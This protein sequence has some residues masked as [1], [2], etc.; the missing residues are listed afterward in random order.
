MSSPII[1]GVALRE[2]DA[3][4]VALA[5][6]LAGVSDRPL[7]LAHVMPRDVPGRLHVPEY[8]QAQRETVQHRLRSVAAALPG[9]RVAETYIVEGSPARGLQELAE[10]L[11]P[12]AVVV[13]STHHGVIGRVLAGDVAAGL[14]HDTPCPVAIA[15]RDH[16]EH[17]IERIGAAYD[18]SPESD[19]AL[20]AAAGIAGRVGAK[21]H[22]YTVLE[23]PD[24]GPPYVAPGWIPSPTDERERREATQAAADR[25]LA[26]IPEELRGG[27]EVIDG[28]VAHALAELS[29]RLDLLVCGSR[30]F[31]P[32][33]A[34]AMGSVARGLAHHASCPL[35][36]V[37]RSVTDQTQRLW[38]APT[39]ESIA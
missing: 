31:G 15:P 5:R 29:A 12:A 1:V 10:E 14:L 9:D 20:A 37:P 18:G 19:A 33:R 28:A 22:A 13:G 8:T 16:A 7:V 2:D 34:V 36:V 6:T 4:P 30:G 24:W 39:A 32:L 26:A 21:V 25:A 23:S 35:L 11:E 38:G 17:A 27:A 3:A